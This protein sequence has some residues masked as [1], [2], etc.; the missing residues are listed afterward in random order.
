MNKV[1]TRPDLV[2]RPE[3][4]RTTLN[5]IESGTD[6]YCFARNRLTVSGE[7]ENED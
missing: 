5:L 6:F 3:H 1:K 2:E 4:A 7:A